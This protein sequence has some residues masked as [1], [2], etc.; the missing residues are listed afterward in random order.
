M[1]SPARGS[2]W[3]AVRTCGQR[4]W[5]AYHWWVVGGAALLATGLG[6]V[7]FRGYHGTEQRSE[8]DFLYLSLQL[9]VLESGATT[10]PVPLSL[11]VARLMAPAVAAYA[12]AALVATIFR[13]ELTALRTRLARD[14]VIVCGLDTGFALARMLRTDDV[15]VVAIERDSTHPRIETCRLQQ[16]PVLVGDARDEQLL[17]RAGIRRAGRLVAVCG[18]DG[19]NMKIAEQARR[20]SARRNAV[21]F[22]AA[23][24][25]LQVLVQVSDPYLASLLT[26]QELARLQPGGAGRA[27]LD[28][29]SLYSGGARALIS[30]Y[31]LVGINGSVP[32]M[33]VVGL[34]RLGRQLVVQAARTWRAEEHTSQERLWITVVDGAARSQLEQLRQAH[35]VLDDTCE[36]R[37]LELAP[38]P[39]RLLRAQV[40]DSSGSPP[41]T[42]V[43]V[44]LPDDADG[45]GV[46]LALH[47]RLKHRDAPVVIRTYDADLAA[48]VP[49][50]RQ[51]EGLAVVDQIDRACRPDQLFAGETD[52]LAQAIHEVYR[53]QRRA[54]G[55]NESINPSMVGWERL[56]EDK[57]DSNRAQAR[58]IASKLA[59]IGCEIGPL[60][61]PRAELF[62]FTPFEIEWLARMEHDRWGEQARPE[63][64]ANI[65]WDELSAPVK[66][67][68]Y[69]F[70]RRMPAVLATAG[71]QIN[72]VRG[73]SAQA[74]AEPDLSGPR[75]S[76]Q[77]QG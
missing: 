67:I 28:F 5:R 10:G 22:R 45:L 7:G 74:G 70:V 39:V 63:H 59:Q 9:F 42:N 47:S 25:P 50:I 11:E 32:H 30:Q 66:E 56:A 26:M 12:V 46:G 77:D 20:L 53:H 48:L 44:C 29:F 36:L 15:R 52:R 34:G 61:D 6:Y 54:A 27:W 49:Q 38:D 76:D 64:P 69:H 3:L 73:A 13:D 37:S 58:H 35:P 18:D 2:P 8:W 41:V 72:R 71:F 19:G 75:G 62:S 43:F 40:F 21:R 65:P 68:D 57:K 14:H 24:G 60:T 17:C 4:W 31:P 55:E 51:P 1:S 23:T 33:V 16:I